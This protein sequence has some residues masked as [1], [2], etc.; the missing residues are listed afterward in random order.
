MNAWIGPVWDDTGV[1]TH[2]WLNRMQLAQRPS[3]DVSNPEHLIFRRLQYLHAI[4]V[5]CLGAGC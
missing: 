2:S 3:E 5:R 4:A 1:K